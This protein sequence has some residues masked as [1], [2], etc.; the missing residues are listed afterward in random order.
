[1]IIRYS[2]IFPSPSHVCPSGYD[3]LYALQR[4]IYLEV[5]SVLMWQKYILED[6]LVLHLTLIW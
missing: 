3:T 6:D 1:M 2:Q 5:S 4:M